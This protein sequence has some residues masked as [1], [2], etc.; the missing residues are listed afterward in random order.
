MATF[1]NSATLS[2]NGNI[3]TSNI[4]TGTLQEVLTATKTAIVDNYTANGNVTYAVSLINGGSTALTNLTLT[5]NLGAYKLDTLTLYPLTYTADSLKY[6]VNGN[7]TVAPS[8]TADPPLEITGINVPANGNVTLIY[9]ATINKFAPLGTES[10]IENTATISGGG[11]STPVTASE[12]INTLDAPSLT[13]SKSLSPTTVTDN[14]QL[15]YTFTIQNFGNTIADSTAAI[16]LT[17]DFDPVLDPIAVT[18][19]GAPWTDPTNYTYNN[20]SGVFST[21]AG[22]ITVPAAKYTQDDTTG[23][24]STEPGVSTLVITGTV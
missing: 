7:P 19:N 2:Y 16:V 24:W 21:V 15:T 10:S 6:S 22:Q 5:D 14:G 8:V 1:T 20:T 12:T 18:F 9:Q 3:T 4:V 11:L 17:D 13:I 23:V